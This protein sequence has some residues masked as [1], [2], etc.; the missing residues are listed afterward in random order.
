MFHVQFMPNPRFSSRTRAPAVELGVSSPDPSFAC[1]QDVLTGRRRPGCPCQLFPL[2]LP[3][4]VQRFLRSLQR[5]VANHRPARVVSW[6]VDLDQSR[7]TETRSVAGHYGSARNAMS[8]R[9]SPPR[10]TISVSPSPP[11]PD[12]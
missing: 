9:Y 11:P 7:G 10:P 1:T 5:Q 12:P 4:S 3:T 2:P 6:Q 8:G